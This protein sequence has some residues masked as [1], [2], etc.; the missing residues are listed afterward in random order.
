MKVSRLAIFA[1]S[2]TALLLLGADGYA[3]L[4]RA[5]QLPISDFAMGKVVL[6]IF[7][8]TGMVLG[9]GTCAA[10]LQSRPKLKLPPYGS[11]EPLRSRLSPLLIVM[12]LGMFSAS[13]FYNGA[14]C[15]DKPFPT[16][17]GIGL[18]E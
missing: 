2:I 17:R 6:A 5:Q 10:W 7:L 13:L 12:L 11:F 14:V 8:Q 16:V 18:C 1:A 3:I 4:V 15:G 9:A